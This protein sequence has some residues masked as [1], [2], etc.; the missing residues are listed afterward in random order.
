MQPPN[1]G[2]LIE[3]LTS[4]NFVLSWLPM[5]LTAVTITMLMLPAMRQYS[6]AVAPHSSS[7]NR[8]SNRRME[9][10]LSTLPEN[11]AAPYW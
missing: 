10:L 7:M 6:I 5:P 2:Y 1:A 11:P 8:A 4:T 9:N 3:A